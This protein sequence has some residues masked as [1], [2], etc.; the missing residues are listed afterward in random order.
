MAWKGKAA[1]REAVM[2]RGKERRGK[3][4]ALNRRKGNALNGAEAA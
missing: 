2:W 3:A 4:Q 1:K